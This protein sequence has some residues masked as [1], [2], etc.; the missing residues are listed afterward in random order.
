MTI[1]PE[2]IATTQFN[3]ADA[4]WTEGLEQEVFLPFFACLLVELTDGNNLDSYRQFLEQT[5]NDANAS[6][7]TGGI[8]QGL[9]SYWENPQHS[10]ILDK[11]HQVSFIEKHSLKNALVLAIHTAFLK[12]EDLANN[13]NLLVNDFILANADEIVSAL[14][15]WTEEVIDESVLANFE[16][17]RLLSQSLKDIPSNQ[18]ITDNNTDTLATMDNDETKPSEDDSDD[19]LSQNYLGNHPKSKLNPMMIAIPAI[20]GVLALGAGV[21]YFYQ[22]NSPPQETVSTETAT[23]APVVASLPPSSLSITVGE[24]GELYACSAELGNSG[25]SDTLI[26]ILQTNFASTLCVIDI[27]EGVSQNIVGLDRLTS[28]LGLLKTAPFATFELRGDTAYINAPN[29]ADI[30]RLVGDIGAILSTTKVL[31]MP[32]LDSTKLIG[33]SITKATDAL[34]SLPT[35][36]K[37]YEIARAMSLQII[38]IQQGTVP[39]INKAVLAL[40]ASFLKNSPDARLIIVVHSDDTGDALSART[41][42]QSIA[43]AIKGEL[44]AQGVADSQLTAQGVGFDFPKADNQT[45]VGRFKNRRVEFLVYDDAVLQA[46]TPQSPA[47]TQTESALIVSETVA[48]PSQPAPVAVQVVEPQPQM[49]PAQPTLAVQGNQIIE[50]VTEPQYGGQPQIVSPPPVSYGNTAGSSSSIPDDLLTPIGT[51]PVNGQA[52]QYQDYSK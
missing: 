48:P 39:D 16:V 6:F 29:S 3:Q 49:P 17:Q 36:A 51:D 28:V 20:I 37:D 18:T 33:D 9:L 22:K 8:T 50:V 34:N 21:Y 25:L 10:N 5:K 30:T 26:N 32:A 42:T 38:D 1:L 23:P 27:N 35:Q 2:L 43:D 24:K 46:L 14:P 47:P 4:I 7:A 45:E 40:S 15:T 13:A 19:S 12:L 11:L 31:P 44:M 41:S 52:T